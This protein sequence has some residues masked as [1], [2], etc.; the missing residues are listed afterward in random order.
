GFLAQLARFIQFA[1]NARR[2]VVERACNRAE[3]ARPPDDD[4]EEDEGDGDPE[5]D[6]LEKGHRQPQCRAAS[7]ARSS[8]CLAG[9]SPVR[10]LTSPL[11]A[12]AAMPRTFAMALFLVV[13]I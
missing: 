2:A 3:R 5:I 13:S 11:A 10:R 6:R 1:A 9:A 7:T 12:S 4:E 8:D